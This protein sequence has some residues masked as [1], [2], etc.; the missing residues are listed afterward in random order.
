MSHTDGRC[1]VAKAQRHET[2]PKQVECRKVLVP[3]WATSDGPRRR[4]SYSPRRRPVAR[5]TE[6]I[7][8]LLD[9]G[10]GKVGNCELNMAERLGDLPAARLQF[11]RQDRH[12]REAEPVITVPFTKKRSSIGYREPSIAS[13]LSMG[14]WNVSLPQYAGSGAWIL[15]PTR[16]LMAGA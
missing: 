2:L 11:E 8:E 1:I 14:A 7:Y 15:W 5:S 6:C 16:C 12:Y 3:R 13:S 4:Q 9:A 10:L